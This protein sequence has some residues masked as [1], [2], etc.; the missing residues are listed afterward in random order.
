LLRKYWSTIGQEMSV[1]PFSAALA[2][3]GGRSWFLARTPVLFYPHLLR[4]FLE[5]RLESTCLPGMLGCLRLS[6]LWEWPTCSASK[7]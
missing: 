4:F 7:R 6:D 3:L 1:D 5:I 2:G